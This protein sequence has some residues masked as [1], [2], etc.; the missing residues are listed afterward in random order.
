MISEKARVLNLLLERNEVSKIDF[1]LGGEIIIT[2]SPKLTKL[3]EHKKMRE[4]KYSESE[5]GA[6]VD[7][8]VREVLLKDKPMTIPEITAAVGCCYQ[9][10]KTAI[11]AATIHGVINIVECRTGELRGKLPHLHQITEDGKKKLNEER[12]WIYLKKPKN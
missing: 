3:Q 1:E 12:W 4:K 11:D 8:R 5:I 6:S 2:L 9:R 7:E 10:A